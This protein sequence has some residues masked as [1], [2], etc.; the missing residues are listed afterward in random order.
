MV[1]IVNVLENKF[2]WANVWASQK[3]IAFNVKDSSLATEFG[4]ATSIAMAG[5]R[6]VYMFYGGGNL[7]L[8]LYTLFLPL[9]ADEES[10]YC[11]QAREAIVAQ[12]N[13]TVSFDMSRIEQVIRN[14][15]TNAVRKYV[16]NCFYLT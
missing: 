4:P 2:S 1:N 5:E 12:R 15:I 3:G 6:I 14:L 9:C 16:V 11:V 13:L 8:L 7:Y 10:G